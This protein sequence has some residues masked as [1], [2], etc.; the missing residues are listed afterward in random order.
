[1]VWLERTMPRFHHPRDFTID[2]WYMLVF[3]P[4]PVMAGFHDIMVLPTLPMTDPYVN[5]RLMRQHDWG[6]CQWQML[7][8]IYHTYIRIRHGH[9]Q[10]N[11]Y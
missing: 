8:Y 2:S 6:F 4:V 11:S 9:C 7:P 3:L 10:S 1:M 5:G